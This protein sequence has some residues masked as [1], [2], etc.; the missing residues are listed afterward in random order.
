MNL[1][2]K[3]R[4]WIALAIVIVGAV[5][6]NIVWV[7]RDQSPPLWDLADHSNR[8][9]IYAGLLRSGEL[10]T[11]FHYDTIYPPLTYLVTGA[12]NM[13]FGLHQDWPQLSLILYVVM[14]LLAVA[15]IARELF[16]NYL[17]TVAAPLFFALF[18]L[19]AHFSRIY[20]L[21]YPL[22]ALVAA[23]IYALIRSRRFDERRWSIAVGLLVAAGLLTKWTF[24]VFF[25]PAA[26]AIWFL[27]AANRWSKA[28]TI[29]I[30]IVLVVIAVLAGPWYLDHYAAIIRSAE[31][32]RQNNFSVPTE[33]LL[34]IKNILYYWRAMSSGISWPALLVAVGGL[35]WLGWKRHRGAII[36]A[37]WVLIP[38]LVMT[39]VFY[40]KESR[41][42]MPVFP[43]LAIA[44]AG[45]LAT[46]PRR[47]AMIVGTALTFILL[48]V[49]TDTSWGTRIFPNYIYRFKG[50]DSTYGYQKIAPSNPRYGFT[51]PTAYQ[52]A[53]K[54]IPPVIKM[55]AIEHGKGN[56]QIVVAVVPNSIFLSE[57]S[58]RWFGSLIKLDASYRISRELRQASWASH[59]DTVDYLVT[60]TGEQGPA[61]F[62]PHLDEIAAAEAQLGNSVFLRFELVKEFTLNG[63]GGASTTARLYRQK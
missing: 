25:L 56:R 16:H 52:T 8:S 21:D 7:V 24:L 32:T 58:L 48:V 3:Q 36:L 29:N 47:L 23:A 30:T 33:Q 11:I 26:L 9:A 1:S 37:G 20:D 51:Y 18:P 44:A 38:Y 41:Y 4:T 27:F 2:P 42:I 43:A 12:G 60:K 54:D 15:S 40:S 62:A 55:D 31:L 50:L 34:S 45:F 61:V 57:R 63:I 49:W 28:R 35:A 14:A 46:L 10:K 5:I 13:V 53:I 17:V 6:A 19:A 39:F 22:T 59:L